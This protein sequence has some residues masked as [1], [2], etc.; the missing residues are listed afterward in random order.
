MDTDI[1]I[2]GS[3]EIVAEAM[4]VCSWLR[5]TFHPP[6][7]NEVHYSDVLLRKPSARDRLTLNLTDVSFVNPEKLC[8][9]PLF[10]NACIAKGSPIPERK[11]DELGIEMALE[12]MAALSDSDHVVEYKG[13]LI[14]KSFSS[15][16]VPVK[17]VANSVQWHLLAN[18]NGQDMKYSQ[19]ESYFPSRLSLREL[20]HSALLETRCFL[21]W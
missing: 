17:R 14:M 2:S 18:E 8:W 10:G 13:G 11:N 5:A 9:L 20:D 19:V 21:G 3:L 12:I 16:L 15:L 1:K 7:N 6:Q 4:K